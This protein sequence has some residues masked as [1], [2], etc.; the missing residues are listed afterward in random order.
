MR[1][2]YL[3]NRLVEIT[4]IPLLILSL[5]YIL[6]GYGMISGT[7]QRILL[8]IG[9]SYSDIINLHTDPHIR[10]L[11]VIIGSI[12][13]LSGTILFISKYIRRVF[14]QDLLILLTLTIFMIVISLVVLSEFMS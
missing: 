4:S 12:H 13:G 1:S 8:L 3:L 2:I 10:Q 5:L 6:T 11:L 9:L 7:M 14:I